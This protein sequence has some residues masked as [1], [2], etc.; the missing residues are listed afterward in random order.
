[1]TKTWITDENGNRCS[2]ERWGSEAEA[3]RVLATNKNCSGCFGC[4]GCSRCF[5]CFGCSDCFGCSRCSGCS[6]DIGFTV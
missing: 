4:F 6:G 1:M 5:G 3:R 2:V